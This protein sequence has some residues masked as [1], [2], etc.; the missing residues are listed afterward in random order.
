MFRSLV[1]RALALILFAFPEI[2][3][4][5]DK[6]APDQSSSHLSTLGQTPDWTALERYQQTITHDQFV[7]LL[8]HVYATRGYGP[9]LIKIDADA[10][11]ILMKSDAHDYF[12]LRFA[13]SEDDR[14]P[15][16]H[17][18]KALPDLP[19]ASKIKP[20][21]G[22]RIALDPG[23]LGG[24]WARMEER[25]FKIGEAAPVKEGEMTLRVAQLLK[26]KLKSLG[27]EV[28]LLRTNSEPVTPSRPRDF[29]KT[30]R[31][32]LQRQGIAKP[33]E[34]F[35]GP[36]DPEKEKTVAWQRELLFYRTSE[37]RHRADLANRRIQPDLV[38]CLH[39]N[40]ESWGDPNRPT[41]VDKNH[42]HLLVNGS[43]LPAEIELDDERFE[44][45]RKLLSRS[46]PEELQIAESVA[47]SLAKTT[48]LPAYRYTTEN[49]TP[50]GTSGYV[51]A[52]NLLATRL[53]RCPTVYLEPYVMNN[54][55]VF[56]RVQAGDYDG[57]KEIAGKKRRSIYREYVD[58][59][60]E[61]LAA[62]FG[63]R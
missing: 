36:A 59:V 10:A 4:A 54:E 47:A 49:V 57:E 21:L 1:T 28:T 35:D 40:A 42:L 48:G 3:G 9:E 34:N 60:V 27:A 18:W 43:Y 50:I 19:K 30:A 7:D 56:Q 63:T 25:W 51:Y 32:L 6:A 53:Y 24:E 13:K 55:E 31:R 38:L 8:D 2:C 37:V 33:R 20:L 5:I 61:G 41:L 29:E 46:Y 45:L 17:W 12:I 14:R 26:P 16:R 11:R 52:R 22:L 44:M 15:V 58:G 39:F 62:C 23:H